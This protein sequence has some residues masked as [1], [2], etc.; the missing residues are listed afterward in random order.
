MN[1][2]EKYA[3]IAIIK[4]SLPQGAGI[5]NWIFDVGK[6]NVIFTNSYHCMNNGGFYDGYA[7][8]SVTVPLTKIYDFKLH[9]HGKKAQYLSKKYNLRTY[10]EDEI[11]YS[12]WKLQLK[13]DERS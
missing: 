1:L 9:F 12:L 8:F 2:D 5:C 7:V 4:E 13:I 6:K 11:Y 10:L 3:L